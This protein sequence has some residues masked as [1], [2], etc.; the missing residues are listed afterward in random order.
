MY[1]RNTIFLQHGL[2]SFLKNQRVH[3]FMRNTVETYFIRLCAKPSWKTRMT[4]FFQPVKGVHIFSLLCRIAAACIEPLLDSLYK[5]GGKRLMGGA[6]WF[7]DPTCRLQKHFHHMS[8]QLDL[9]EYYQRLPSTSWCYLSCVIVSLFS[10]RTR[11]FW[12]T[13]NKVEQ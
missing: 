6:L 2:V 9:V 3:L 12:P 1:L 13:S 7:K 8:V 11:L 4:R 5:S 10:I